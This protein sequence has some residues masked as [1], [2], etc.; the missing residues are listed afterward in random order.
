MTLRSEEIDPRILAL[1][2]EDAR[3][4]EPAAIRSADAGTPLPM[5]TRYSRVV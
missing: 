3:R 4:S 1:L 5:P 2:R